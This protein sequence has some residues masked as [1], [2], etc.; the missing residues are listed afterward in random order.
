M[1]INIQILIE[2]YQ[3]GLTDSEL[4]VDDL[5][6]SIKASKINAFISVQDKQALADASALAGTMPT[7]ERPLHGI[8]VAIKD[9]I[10][11]RGCATTMGAAGFEDN[12]ASV[13]AEV[14][15][16]IRAAGAILIGKTNTHQ[17]AYGPRPTCLCWMT[18]VWAPSTA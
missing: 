3:E 17:F 13:D 12:V 6:E 11:V 16:R 7:R 10:D 8:A 5:L 18:G 2:Q 1:T 14:V 4:V 9:L 15:A